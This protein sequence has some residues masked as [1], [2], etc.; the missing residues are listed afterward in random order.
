MF[1]VR[2]QIWQTQNCLVMLALFCLLMGK[3]IAASYQK[4]QTGTCGSDGIT[5]KATCFSAAT[6]LGLSVTTAVERSMSNVPSGCIWL[7]DG[8]LYYNPKSSST[9]SCSSNVPCLCR[10]LISCTGNTANGGTGGNAYTTDCV[11]SDVAD[12]ASCTLTCSAPGYSGT[13]TRLCTAGSFAALVAPTCT[14]NT[15]T[16]PNGTPTVATGS[17]GTLCESNGDV[18]CSICGTSYSLSIAAAAGTLSTCDANSCTD[19]TAN[20]GTGNN[21]YTTDCVSSDVASGSSCTLTCSAPGY[22]GTSTRLCT[23]GSFAALVAPT[24]TANTCT[25][26]NG[27]PTVATGS[28]G[29]LC[30]SNGD[31]DCSIC[32]TSY[33]LSIAAAAGTLSTC[34]A[35]S[36]T[37]NTANGGTGNNAYTTDC[38]SS[39]VA[40][41]S[42]CTLTCSAP[43]YSGTSTRLCTV[44]SFATL[45]APTCT[46]DPCTT[47]TA[48][49]GTG[50]NTYTTNCASSDV[51]SGSSCTLTCSAS[52]YSGTSTRLCT[53]GSFVALV[54]PSCRVC[55]PVTFIQQQTIESVKDSTVSIR[56]KLE[57]GCSNPIPYV[58]IDLFDVRTG[59]DE[60]LISNSDRQEGSVNRGERVETDA[61]IEYIELLLDASMSISKTELLTLTK[62]IVESQ[63]EEGAS[64]IRITVFSGNADETFLLTSACTEGYCSTKEQLYT[65]LDGIWTTLEGWSKYDP[66]ASAVFASIMSASASNIVYA[67]AHANSQFNTTS[68]TTSISTT[69]HLVVFTDLD[70]TV[71]GKTL[72]HATDM[73]SWVT[74]YSETTV[75]IIVLDP[76]P[77]IET[78]S[79]K[80][81]KNMQDARIAF[82]VVIPKGVNHARDVTQLA[83]AFKKD[84][85]LAVD[86]AN[87]WYELVVCPPSRAGKHAITVEFC[88][89]EK[90]VPCSETKLESEFDANGFSSTCPYQ[91]KTTKEVTSETCATRKCGF[92]GGIFCGTCDLV[93]GEQ[94]DIRTR[95]SPIL[96]ISSELQKDLSEGIEFITSYT[97]EPILALY[98]GSGRKLIRTGDSMFEGVSLINNKIYDDGSF[99][100]SHEILVH[101]IGTEASKI[102]TWVKFG[103]SVTDVGAGAGGSSS[104]NS[105]SSSD[106]SSSDVSIGIKTGEESFWIN[107]VLCLSILLTS[108]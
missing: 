80:Q 24:C 95:D 97:K 48:N 13:S 83:D 4:K 62:S 93:V 36:C 50:N 3:T 57:D 1:V 75:S 78:N 11:S 76:A 7:S 104:G 28:A 5:D 12:G 43:G 10:I 22:S 2:F 101:V 68:S 77:G 44:G 8:R 100:G 31:V 96:K 92:H 59:L 15:C 86:E 54:A 29:T 72:K 41:G 51:V 63:L 52:E 82:E 106:D 91:K 9:I 23:A 27:T 105:S 71:G 39:D 26:P 49:G 17:A 53:A 20:G 32:G 84:A 89:L 85:K 46:A 67:Q 61:A 34:D 107:L 103:T 25:C 66:Q 6:Y 90:T 35:N 73:V 56:F 69:H 55:G 38:V 98:V 37:D 64:F 30:E 94:I 18:D 74:K 70:D 40:S 58:P 19:N 33:S 99:T 16:C 45:V 108:I 47:N 42:S 88:G 87:A 21:A 81:F 65:A 14:A 79:P 102:H 60:R